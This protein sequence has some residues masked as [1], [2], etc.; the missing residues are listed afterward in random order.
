[1]AI[2]DEREL[3]P[4]SV[5]T[6]RAREKL[7]KYFEDVDKRIT[8]QALGRKSLEIHRWIAR[9]AHQRV[10]LP[11]KTI[12]L[13]DG[14]QNAAKLSEKIAKLAKSLVTPL[15]PSLDNFIDKD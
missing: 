5:K 9:H 1:M 4:E 12:S 10:V 8:A 13:F 7:K 6:R 11:T 14:N 3:A 2:K 15:E